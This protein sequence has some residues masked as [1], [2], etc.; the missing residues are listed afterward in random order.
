MRK[1]IK[2]A[3]VICLVAA[4]AAAM[5][6]DHYPDPETL[7]ELNLGCDYQ[8]LMPARITAELYNESYYHNAI[9][10]DGTAVFIQF[11]IH[12]FGFGSFH[13]SADITM[14]TPDGKVHRVSES[15]DSDDVAVASDGFRIKFL[16][17]VLEGETRGDPPTYHIRAWFEEAGADL[18][19]SCEAP[20]FID[21][22]T[23]ING[24]KENYYRVV[25]YCPKASVKGKVKAS[26]REWEVKGRGY[27]DHAKTM[28]LAPSQGD[29][30][31]QIYQRGGN[32][33]IS[34]ALQHSMGLDSGKK[35]AAHCL[36]I[37]VGDRNVFFSREG[38]HLEILGV[39]VTKDGKRYPN[40][41]TIEAKNE[42]FEYRGEFRQ[43]RFLLY[44][45]LFDRLNAV[46][47][48]TLNL[49]GGYPGYYRYISRHDYTYTFNGEAKSGTTQT[50]SQIIYAGEPDFS[51]WV[52]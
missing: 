22:G 8:D 31:F 28:S 50:I 51:T 47:K 36:L 23:Y 32:T 15:Y 26:G 52:K 45:G 2:A 38:Y 46:F 37:A 11:F 49:L 25:N 39:G 10:D 9:L 6:I 44:A 5:T 29:S 12:N 27:G 41:F 43:E 7:A 17:H 3:V 1:A 35:F 18:V 34:L 14:V 4:A 48:T 20:A 19:Y 33:D 30:G 24:D 13:P 42:W 21:K 40:A 16:D